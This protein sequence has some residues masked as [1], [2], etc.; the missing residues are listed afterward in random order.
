MAKTTVDK[1]LKIARAEVGTRATNVKRCK[2]N[3]AFYGAEVSGDCYDWC[4][5]FV[6]WV[7]K[8]AGADD[9]LLAAVFLLRLFITKVKL[10]V[11][12]IKLAM[13]CCFTG[14]MRQVQLFRALML[15]T[16]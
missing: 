8:Q 10:F 6:W 2:Y 4:A 11:V 14:V 1:I 12:V 13:L 15:L 16:M 7:F 5:A 3:T 9:M